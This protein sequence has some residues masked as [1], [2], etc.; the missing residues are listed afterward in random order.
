MNASHAN[1]GAQNRRQGAYGEALVG[2]VAAAAGLACY[3]PSN[4]L[5]FDRILEAESGELVR[6]QIKTTFSSLAVVGGDLRY[7]L[8]VQAYER[9]RKPYTVRTYLVVV[10]VRATEKEWTATMDWG[11]VFRRDAYFVSLTGAAPTAN[12]TEVTVSLPLSNMVSAVSLAKLVDG[13]V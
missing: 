3:E 1:Q 12:V 7:P 9:L 2:A 5:G 4:D 11:F 6:L 10:R 13:G 8:D